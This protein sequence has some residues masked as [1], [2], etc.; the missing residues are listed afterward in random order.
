MLFF[1]AITTSSF[2]PQKTHLVEHNRDNHC[3]P[4]T[5]LKALVIIITTEELSKR[6]VSV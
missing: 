4:Y 1:W 5:H 3:D 2:F 6:T